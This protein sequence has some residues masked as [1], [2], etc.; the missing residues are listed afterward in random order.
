MQ[1]LCV[2]IPRHSLQ[3]PVLSWETL[4]MSAHISVIEFIIIIIMSLL[5]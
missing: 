3:I 1:T 5:K 4:R 2:Y